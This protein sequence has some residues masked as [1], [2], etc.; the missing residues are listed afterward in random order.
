MVDISG[1]RTLLCW[2]NSIKASV[3]KLSFLENGS[4]FHILI[5]ELLGSFELIFEFDNLG[6][7]FCVSKTEESESLDLIVSDSTAC[8]RSKSQGDAGV[9]NQIPRGHEPEIALS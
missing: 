8:D 9:A 4:G 3:R 1:L 2:S 7:N 6:L 5:E